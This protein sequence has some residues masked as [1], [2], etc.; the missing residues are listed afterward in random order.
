M[1]DGQKKR[2][3]QNVMDQPSKSLF[4]CF[5]FL[6]PRCYITTTPINS[7]GH[8]IFKQSENKKWRG[9]GRESERYSKKKNKKKGKYRGNENLE[10]EGG[11]IDEEKKV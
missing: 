2:N 4:S 1:K 11:G 6:R 8:I 5:N 3:K 9:G 7:D 10:R